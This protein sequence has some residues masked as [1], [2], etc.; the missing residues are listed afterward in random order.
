MMADPW[1][2]MQDFTRV[3]DAAA[4]RDQ[5]AAEYHATETDRVQIS[6]RTHPPD[7]AMTLGC[8]SYVD[9]Q[10]IANDNA[11]TRHRRHQGRYWQ[12]QEREEN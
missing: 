12:V 7:M 4:A 1:E 8:K 11:T 6:G 10:D 9:T 3:M 5:Q 2:M